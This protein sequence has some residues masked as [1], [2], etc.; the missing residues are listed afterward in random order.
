V[1]LALRRVW[2]SSISFGLSADLEALPAA[3]PARISVRM[4]PADTASFTGFDED[5][6]RASGGGSVEVA[7]RQD[8]CAAGVATLYVAV[9]DSGMP[10]Y[11]QW[12]IRRHEQEPLHRKAHGLF[13]QLEETEALLEG[14][15]TF[16]D[17]RRLGAMADGM[18]QLLVEAR[19]AGDRKVFTYVAED[20]VPSLRGCANVGFVLDHLRVDRRRLGVRRVR[21]V[22]PDSASKARWAA[23]VE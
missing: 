15:Y 9:D 18:R 3:R 19:D 20:N 14:A 23:A 17:F 11:A 2:S 6:K 12:L 7:D 10:I 8:L 5:A 13:P 21:R 1:L 4:E 22:R 16:L